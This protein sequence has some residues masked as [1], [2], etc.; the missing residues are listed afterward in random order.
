[1]L[2]VAEPGL[3]CNVLILPPYIVFL[4]R[5]GFDFFQ[6]FFHSLINSFM[7][8]L[9]FKCLM[10]QALLDSVDSVIAKPSGFSFPFS[11]N[12]HRLSMLF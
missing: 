2:T 4:E 7:H 1:M 8:Y 3:T 10:W 12:Y 6:H 5:K 9:F 11:Q